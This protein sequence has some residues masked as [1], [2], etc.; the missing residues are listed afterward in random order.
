MIYPQILI[1]LVGNAIKFTEKGHVTIHCTLKEQIDE[2][3]ILIQF[4]IEDSGIG[5]SQE[6][7]EKIF[8]S[9]TQAGTDTAR[10]FGGTGL[11]LTISKQLV[12]LMHGEIS[13][14]SKLNEGTVFTVA[15]PIEIAK[16]QEVVLKKDEITTEIRE[17][18]SNIS[19]L[20]V[21]DNEFNRLVA[22][23]TL[24]SLENGEIAIQKLK[25]DHFDLILMDIQMPVMNGVDATRIIRTEM[26]ENI[27]NI[28]IIAMTANVLQE[29]V[30][31]YL[32]AGMD[33]YISKPF[34]TEELLI[35]MNF[36]LEGKK[37]INVKKEDNGH[38][39]K[40][41]VLPA[42]NVFREWT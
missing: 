17:R 31:R 18:L 20:L 10:K 6:Y 40:T 15:M 33:A 39:S 2:R 38:Q 16:E 1:N 8:E 21:E 23:D 32:K 26:S 28:K 13:V 36:V 9:F 4:D 19:V 41:F 7:V 5:I 11:G 42:K 12:D 25:E 29:D 34:Q 14:K 35:K 3:N 30:E 37:E 22:E 24:K 27:R